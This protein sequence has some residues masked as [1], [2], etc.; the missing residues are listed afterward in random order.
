MASA[1]VDVDVPAG[2]CVEGAHGW[3]GSNPHVQN[4]IGRTA[5]C[6]LAQKPHRHFNPRERNRNRRRIGGDADDRPDV[7]A[8]LSVPSDGGATPEM[9]HRK[10]LRRNIGGPW[11]GC[12]RRGVRVVARRHLSGIFRPR[13]VLPEVLHI[14]A[15][16]LGSMQHRIR[17]RCD[18]GFVNPEFPVRRGR[19]PGRVRRPVRWWGPTLRGFGPVRGRV[20]THHR[21]SPP[22]I[23]RS[24]LL[25]H[26][27]VRHGVT[28]T[29]VRAAC[30]QSDC[31][32][33]D[34][35]RYT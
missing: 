16:A 18:W 26:I 28:T 7:V 25:N 6:H 8:L 5:A 19:W 24:N 1:P 34:R 32:R 9:L 17:G 33:G 31:M 21:P 14:V 12:R 3:V 13:A 4:R 11:W 35:D 27:R 23:E 10:I 22:Q 15:A 30:G 2:T 29:G 20:V